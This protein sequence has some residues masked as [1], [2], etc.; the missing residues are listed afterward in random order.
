MFK[1]SFIQQLF[2]YTGIMQLTYFTDLQLQLGGFDGINYTLHTDNPAMRPI[3]PGIGKAGLTSPKLAQPHA[4]AFA[5]V[6]SQGTNLRYAILISLESFLNGAI[7][8]WS[9]LL[10]SCLSVTSN[11]SFISSFPIL[12]YVSSSSYVSHFSFSAFYDFLPLCFTLHE[13]HHR[14]VTPYISASKSSKLQFLLYFMLSG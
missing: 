12:S 3:E 1:D 11:L 9:F 14:I 7:L 8:L 10:A 5:K 6:S 13:R 2:L 4:L